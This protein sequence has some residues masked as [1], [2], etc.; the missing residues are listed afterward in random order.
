MRKLFAVATQLRF[1]LLLAL[2]AGGSGWISSD[3]AAASLV[4]VNSGFEDISGET[5]SNEF[6]FGPFNGWDLYDPNG[7]T[8]GG[9]GPTY[10][11]GTLTPVEPDPI[12]APGVFTF[13]PDGAPE[14]QRVGIAFSYVGTGGQGEWGL[15]Q[16]LADTLQP[17]TLYTLQVR[18]GNIA[19]GTSVG[20]GVF[21][22]DGF[23]GYRVDLLAGGIIVAQDDNSLAGT[24]PE[25]EFANTTV[26]LTTGTTHAQLGLPLGIR[27]VNL[28]IADPNHPASDLEVDF[29]DVR[30]DTTPAPALIPVLS[31]RY[32]LLLAMLLAGL[33]ASRLRSS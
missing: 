6:T 17:E 1:F 13:F 10:F 31:G 23:P 7:V 19:S 5:P 21:P 22:L 32:E 25:G 12:G 18:I 3:A 27:L 28:N 26:E 20:G 11:I 14:G 15:V 4:L 29:D 2:I 9:D 30:L 16:T 33:V 8:D 24:I